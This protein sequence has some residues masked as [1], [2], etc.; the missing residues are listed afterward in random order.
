MSAAK[1]KIIKK[2]AKKNAVKKAP[3]KKKSYLPQYVLPLVNYL[4]RG[5]GFPL[6]DF[7][8]AEHNR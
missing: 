6:L 1:K 3:A 4:Y 2:P 7:Q 5:R 8:I